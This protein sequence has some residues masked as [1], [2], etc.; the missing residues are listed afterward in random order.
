MSDPTFIP[1]VGSV[2][3]L[4][5]NDVSLAANVTSVNDERDVMVKKVFGSS[6]AFK[7]PG[8]GSATLEVGGHVT[9]EHYPLIETAFGKKFIDFSVQVGEGGA[10]TDGGLYTGTA[11]IA[12]KSITAN[13]DGEW[14]FS[15]TLEVTGALTYTPPS[16]GS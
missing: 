1:G 12:S 4:D 13:A 10:A 14:D 5:L 15:L 8:I 11:V 6:R 7:V 9:V 3:T 16:P 2:I